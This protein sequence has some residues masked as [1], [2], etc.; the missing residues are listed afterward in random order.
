MNTINDYA[1]KLLL[2]KSLVISQD[3]AGTI[4]FSGNDVLTLK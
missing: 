3:T 4:E 1:T 2:L